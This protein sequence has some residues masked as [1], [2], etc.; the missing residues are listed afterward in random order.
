MIDFREMIAVE[1]E[2]DRSRVT[3]RGCGG[4]EK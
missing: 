4:Q 2:S 3:R 1:R